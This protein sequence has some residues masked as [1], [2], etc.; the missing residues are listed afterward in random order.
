MVKSGQWS[1][2]NHGGGRFK[3]QDCQLSEQ[4]TQGL[5][6]FESGQNLSRVSMK[7]F[8]TASSI[9]LF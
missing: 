6:T 4:T 7:L 8:Q 9:F 2:K 5:N 1:K 3:L